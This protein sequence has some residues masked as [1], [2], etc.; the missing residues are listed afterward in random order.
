MLSTFKIYTYSPPGTFTF[1][2]EPESLFHLSLLNSPFLTHDPT[3]AHLY[4]VPFPP[5]ISPR[6]LTRYI[7]DLRVKFPYW[8]R[9][10]GAD[11]VYISCAGLSYSSDR[12]TLELKKNAVQVSAFPT[13]SGNFIPHKDISLPP[14]PSPLALPHAPTN[15]TETFVTFLNQDKKGQDLLD[16]LTKDPEFMIASG[17][18]D[19]GKGNYCVFFYSGDVSLIGQALAT[20]CVPVVITNRPI[21]D[22][23]LMDVLRWQD[24]A[25]FVGSSGG[26]G[27]LKQ[28]VSGI[29]E[30]KYESMRRLG[31]AAAQHLLWNEMP[32]QLDA[33][34]M[35]MYQLWLRRHTIRYARWESA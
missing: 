6:A 31:V 14:Y 21:Q 1:P 29:S 33:F 30:D 34:H 20:G 16:E 5:S 23:P 7:K 22:L 9:T 18:S 13:L 28:V 11:H 27:E 15:K 3:Q 19:L 26:V 8:N 24:I 32:Q 12:N 10:L 2:T 35:V 4:L 25:V 17:P